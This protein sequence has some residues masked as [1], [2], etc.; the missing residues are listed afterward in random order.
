MIDISVI[1]TIPYIQNFLSSKIL[2]T[3]ENLLDSFE[4]TP[5]LS[6]QANLTEIPKLAN[7]ASIN[8]KL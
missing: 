8:C 6:A 1:D 3:S 7:D 4:A 2:S 5:S